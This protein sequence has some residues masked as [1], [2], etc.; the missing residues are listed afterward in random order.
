MNQDMKGI[1]PKD[2]IDLMY[3]TYF[4]ISMEREILSR[5]S[6]D[7]TPVASI[8]SESLKTY[9]IPLPPLTEQEQIV[10]EVERRLS[11]ISQLESTV[12]A[13][14]KRAERLRQSILK[15]AFAGRLVPQDPDDEPASV[16]LERI[17]RD[18]EKRKHGALDKGREVIC[19]IPKPKK[20]DV[21][22]TKQVELWESISSGE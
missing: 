22:R 20:I 3:I 9:L 2:G 12:E 11:V 15:E 18:R 17:R 10:A 19:E 8:E 21:K 5:C 1:S 16:L 6:K 7:G 4:L 13:N 14:L